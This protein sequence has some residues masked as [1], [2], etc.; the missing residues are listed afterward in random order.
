MQFGVDWTVGAAIVAAEPTNPIRV[1][2]V[3]KTSAEDAFGDIAQ[4]LH[5]GRIEDRKTLGDDF[6]PRCEHAV[7]RNLP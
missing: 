7:A 4:E 6:V 1:L 5:F 2:E 3:L